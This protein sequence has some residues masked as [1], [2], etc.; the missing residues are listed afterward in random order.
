MVYYNTHNILIK[1]FYM[2]S[3]TFVNY[4]KKRSFRDNFAVI[5]II[6]I[7]ILSTL[8][9]KKK[10]LSS[11]YYETVAETFVNRLRKFVYFHNSEQYLLYSLLVI[12]RYFHNYVVP[13]DSRDG[14][15]H[16]MY[17]LLQISSWLLF[18]NKYASITWKARILP[19]IA[20]AVSSSDI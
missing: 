11:Y 7:T 5:T 1:D 8:M 10:D 12:V 4:K 13:F 3:N 18:I 19:W 14:V 17:I 6:V 16:F 9:K 20:N 2:F 15:L